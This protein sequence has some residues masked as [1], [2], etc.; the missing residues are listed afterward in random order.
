MRAMWGREH[1]FL[2]ATCFALIGAFYVAPVRAMDPNRCSV[3]DL[4]Q[5]GDQ[6]AEGINDQISDLQRRL[7]QAQQAERQASAALVQ[8]E[9]TLAK[10]RAGLSEARAQWDGVNF[11]P[12]YRAVRDA[13]DYMNGAEVARSR[14]SEQLTWLRNGIREL[15][16]QLDRL[17]QALQRIV[18]GFGHLISNPN[19]HSRRTN[20]ETA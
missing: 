10:A 19:N 18:N 1:R 20:Y 7:A 6:A 5:M 12:K 17:K 9:A 2:L 14:L 15:Q 4:E 11:G 8:A 3:A 16:Q 13:I